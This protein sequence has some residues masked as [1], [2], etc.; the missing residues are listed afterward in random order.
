MSKKNIQQILAGDYWVHW[1]YTQDEWRRF[2]E[3]S[4]ARSRKV[5]LI[6]FGCAV[7][8]T[9]ACSLL[10]IPVYS[11][12]FDLKG[13]DWEPGLFIA[14]AI[15]SGLFITAGL[16]VYMV[17]HRQYRKRLEQTNPYVYISRLGIY[18]PEGYVSLAGLYEAKLQQRNLRFKC[19]TRHYIGEKSADEIEVPVPHGHEQ[20]AEQLLQQLHEWL[21]LRG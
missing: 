8:L 16:L 2:A 9:I 11:Q 3:Q 5:I 15:L 6:G 10:L 20:E 17:N 1:T 18:R 7:L 21:P 13:G 4:W 19:N 12:L 14:M